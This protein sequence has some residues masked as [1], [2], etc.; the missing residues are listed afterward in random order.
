MGNSCLSKKKK[1]NKEINLQYETNIT[2]F[3]L[4]TQKTVYLHQGEKK[5][6]SRRSFHFK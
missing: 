4:I 6:I 3:G 1:V 2:N 5:K